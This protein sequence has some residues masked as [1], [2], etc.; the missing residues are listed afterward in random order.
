MSH[1]MQR[2]RCSWVT[3]DP[4]YIQYHDEEWGNLAHFCDDRYL[5]EMLVLESM[6]AGLNWLT[7]LKRRAAL[8]EAFA[9]FNPQVVAGFN[10]AKIAELLNNKAIIRNRKKIEAAIYNAQAFL[11]VQK[12]FGSFQQ[13]LWQFVGE[14]QQINY[15]QTSAEVPTQT[16]TSVR[17]SKELKRRGFTFVGPVICYSY[18]QAIG[19]VHDHTVD[20][21]KHI[22]NQK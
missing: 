20:C 12:E 11:N 14:K 4:I 19:L 9:D 22:A 17:L 8:R 16:D 21:F 3:D 15:F 2:K 13:F 5:F 7:I 6:Q 1:N 18:M 10:D